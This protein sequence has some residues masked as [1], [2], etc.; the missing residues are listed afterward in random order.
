MSRPQAK[1]KLLHA[2]LVLLLTAWLG[3]TQSAFAVFL[4]PDHSDLFAANSSPAEH[5]GT[6]ALPPKNR[7]WENFGNA[8]EFTSADELNSPQLRWESRF[9]ELE[10]AS[11]ALSYADGNPISLNNPF[12]LCVTQAQWDRAGELWEADRARLPDP[13]IRDAT[14]DVQFA[15]G[16][17]G[18]AR[19]LT[20]LGA[21][22]IGKGLSV[23]GRGGVNGIT[24]QVSSTMA[25]V[26]SGSGPFPA[27]GPPGRADVFVTAADDIAGMTP[28]QI[29]QR[30]T[31]PASDTF[32]IFR[33]PTPSTGVASPILRTDSGFIG[34]GRTLG[35]ARE[36]VLPNEPI[37]SGATSTILGP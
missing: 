8:N 24:N 27:L 5:Q 16:V 29:S 26:V 14:F 21:S 7:V 34:G 31:I 12:G 36:F 1:L 4:P 18:M 17:P 35:G 32:T 2:F 9:G 25:R 28:A 15:L 11:G 3:L 13:G 37:P 33:F 20:E 19:G 22:A 23:L 30:L 6:D 10:L